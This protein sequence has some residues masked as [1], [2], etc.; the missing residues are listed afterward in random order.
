MSVLPL[1]CIAITVAVF[2][3]CVLVDYVRVSLY[4]LIKKAVNNAL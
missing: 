4:R 1:L 2:A 3:V